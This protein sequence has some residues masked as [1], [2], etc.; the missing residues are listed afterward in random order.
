MEEL[1]KQLGVKQLRTTAYHPQTDGAVEKF[2][3]T[4]GDMLT[5]HVNKNPRNWDLQLD[6]CVSCYNQTPHL[7]TKETPFFLLK[8]RDPLEPTDLRPP[9]RYRG[10]E[11]E[12]NVF[13]QSWHDA[14]EL[15]KAHLIIAQD[16][17]KQNYDKNVR[18]CSFNLGDLVLLRESKAQT[19]KFYMRWDGPFVIDDKLSELNYVIRRPTSNTTQL[20]HINRLKLW[21]ENEV[22]DTE[23]PPTSPQL[24]E[25]TEAAIMESEAA[26]PTTES[27][28][29][30]DQQPVEQVAKRKDDNKRRPGRPRKFPKPYAM[31]PPLVSIAQQT[32]N[33]RRPGRPR[34]TDI[35]QP[36][37]KADNNI[38]HT[39][40]T[41]TNKRRPGRP[42]KEQTNNPLPKLAPPTN[43]YNFRTKTYKPSW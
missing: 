29:G 39:N 24:D 12:N 30:Q 26:P 28:Q 18:K 38:P 5:A 33:K 41:N 14:M 27:K 6:Y 37:N 13:T 42:R 8:G 4:L 21:K 32:I 3:K 31:Q 11:D 25:P 10:L 35:V 43:R 2:N 1:C 15:A 7:S 9:M 19:G 22:K 20:V 23:A 36:T 16:T 40:T 17:Q 34:K